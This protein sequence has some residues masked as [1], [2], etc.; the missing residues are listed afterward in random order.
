MWIENWGFLKFS[1]SWIQNLQ[2]N[3]SLVI[4]YVQKLVWIVVLDF[5]LPAIS[6]IAIYILQVNI[7]SSSIFRYIIYFFVNLLLYYCKS[8][9]KY[10]SIYAIDIN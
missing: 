9:V 7:S 5:T 2:L 4:V 1:E 3:T 10:L 6:T 8:D